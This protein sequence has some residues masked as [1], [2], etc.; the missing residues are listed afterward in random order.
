[1]NIL[2]C[3]VHFSELNITAKAVTT[4]FCSVDFSELWRLKPCMSI[5]S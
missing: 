2:I 1:M 3:S 4:N 5:A